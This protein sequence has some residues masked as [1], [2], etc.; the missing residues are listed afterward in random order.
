MSQSSSYCFTNISSC[1]AGGFPSHLF[2]KLSARPN[3]L[4]FIKSDGR[5]QIGLGWLQ[6]TIH[7]LLALHPPCRRDAGSSFPRQTWEPMCFEAVREQSLRDSADH[8]ALPKTALG[9]EGLC[10]QHRAAPC[11]FSAELSCCHFWSSFGGKKKVADRLKNVKN[12]Q[13]IKIR[14]KHGENLVLF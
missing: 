1:R 2:P 14:A 4:L 9:W 13:C 5:P 3:P 10:H 11:G 6:G 7:A 8:S 12:Y